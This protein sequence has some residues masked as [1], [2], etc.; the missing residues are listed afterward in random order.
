MSTIAASD[1]SVASEVV[2]SDRRSVAADLA[3]A[4][5]RRIFNV[6][7]SVNA[8]PANGEYEVVIPADSLSGVVLSTCRLSCG[9]YLLGLSDGVSLVK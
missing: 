8:Q 6:P 2:G 9:A 4:Y 7:A 3:A 5:V 1:A